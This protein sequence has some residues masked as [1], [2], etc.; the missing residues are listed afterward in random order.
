MINTHFSKDKYE[1]RDPLLTIF[2]ILLDKSLP[3]GYLQ[4]LLKT[5]TKLLIITGFEYMI[6]PYER[7][8]KIEEEFFRMNFS[9]NKIK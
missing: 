2:D 8:L 4:H 6:L 3:V 7:G 1:K 5:F 9:E